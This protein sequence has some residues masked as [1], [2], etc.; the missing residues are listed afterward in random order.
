M[1][2]LLT[3]S[4]PD[5]LVRGY[6]PT[7][8]R[9]QAQISHFR[10]DPRKPVV[11]LHPDMSSLK[12]MHTKRGRFKDGSPKIN[13]SRLKATFVIRILPFCNGEVMIPARLAPGRNNVR[14]RFVCQRLCG[15]FNVVMSASLSPAA[16][17]FASL[18]LHPSL[19]LLPCMASMDATQ[20]PHSGGRIG[21]FVCFLSVEN[22]S[23][24]LDDGLLHQ[25]A[26]IC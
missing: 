23:F 13:K 3:S 26:G 20:H 18:I 12:G 4:L 1:L 2:A 10:G 16:L 21:G 5:V 7:H 8:F 17:F 24:V 14:T 25:C 6:R 15:K 9:F 19:Q 11:L 22:I